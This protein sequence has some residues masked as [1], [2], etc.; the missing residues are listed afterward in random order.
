MGTDVNEGLRN[1]ELFS[2]VI[3][4]TQLVMTPM[5]LEHYCESTANMEN[6]YIHGLDRLYF[7]VS[8]AFFTKFLRFTQER[9]LVRINW[10]IPLSVSWWF[11]TDCLSTPFSYLNRPF[12]LH[13]GFHSLSTNAFYHLSPFLIP[14]TPSS[15]LLSFKSSCPAYAWSYFALGP[16]IWKSYSVSL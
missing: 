9:I 1:R 15:F 2:T 10:L 13:P 16:L 8:Q 14:P 6:C 11:L 12:L 3:P 7:V 5:H 4:S